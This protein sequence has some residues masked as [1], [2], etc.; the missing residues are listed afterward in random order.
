MTS[1][2]RRKLLMDY[3]KFEENAADLKILMRP[4]DQNMMIC[5]A[6]IFGPDDTEWE[7][8]VFRLKMEFSD[9]Y[10]IEAP[11]V[12]FLTPMFHPN[13]YADC[14]I[15]LDILGNKWSRL[16]DCVA[17]LTS[18]QSLLTDPNTESPANHEAAGLYTEAAGDK[19]ALYYRKVRQCVEESWIYTR[20]ALPD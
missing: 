5:E 13:I 3:R 8:G 10:P 9:K 15:C 12:R 17:I 19:N 7:S 16:Y 20:P 14:N 4:G 18:L 1:A 11:K 2:A 6:I